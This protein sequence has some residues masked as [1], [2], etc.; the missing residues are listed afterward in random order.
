MEHRRRRFSH[1]CVLTTGRFVVS[2][3]TF[4][5]TDTLT[6][7]TN[8]HCALEDYWVGTIEFYLESSR[9]PSS[10]NNAPNN[11][12]QDDQ[13]HNHD[14]HQQNEQ[15]NNTTSTDTKGKD[16]AELKDLKTKKGVTLADCMLANPG[17]YDKLKDPNCMM[18]NHYVYDELKDLKTENGVILTD[19]IVADPGVYHPKTENGVILTD[20]I[21]AETGVYHPK[22]EDGVILTDCTVAHPGVYDKV[23]SLVPK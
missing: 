14:N 21:V 19:R 8:A 4:R 1:R 22:T 3:K 20:R 9:A 5:H 18:V 11:C 17:V 13:H 6:N 2:G 16:D 12:R 23:E 10:S 7:S 15:R